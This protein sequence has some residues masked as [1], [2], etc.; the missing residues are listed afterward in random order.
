MNVRTRGFT[1]VELLVLIVV[2][3]ILMAMFIHPFR[4]GI[5]QAK[6]ASCSNN[7]SQMWKMMHI[8]RVQFGGPAEFMPAATGGA[9]WRMIENTVPPLIDVTSAEIF[10][11][12][13]RTLTAR[14]SFTPI[15]MPHPTEQ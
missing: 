5:R 10:L 1:L 7:L 11:C 15:Y 9:F 2:I 13:P 8:Y 12:L 6:I 4:G 3:G 14:P